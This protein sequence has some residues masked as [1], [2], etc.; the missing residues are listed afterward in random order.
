MAAGRQ[1]VAVRLAWAKCGEIGWPRLPNVACKTT[2][3]DFAR[4]VRMT[5]GDS[6]RSAVLE[7]LRVRHLADALA[8][9]LASVRPR[10]AKI[11]RL[12]PIGS[13]SSS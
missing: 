2:L 13:Y 10:I 8:S 4:G 3:L 5:P 12:R 1:S 9:E 7:V 6:R 11:G